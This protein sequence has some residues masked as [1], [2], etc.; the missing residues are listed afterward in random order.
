MNLFFME[1]IMKKTSKTRKILGGV[2]LFLMCNF[3]ITY[4]L[5]FATTK[6]MYNKYFNNKENK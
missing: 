5:A 1:K 4:S 2:K 3:V 6:V